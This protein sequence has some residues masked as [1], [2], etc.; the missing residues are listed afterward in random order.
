[1]FSFLKRRRWLFGLF[2]V[3]SLAVG[4]FW[5][6][7]A[8]RLGGYMHQKTF[9][10]SS[11]ADFCESSD[12]AGFPFRLR[13]SCA[14]FAAPLRIGGG[15]IIVKTEE[16]HG[17]ANIFAPNHII[18]TLSSP[19]NLQKA[20]GAPLARLRHDGLTLDVAWKTSGLDKASLDIVALD[21]RPDA[22]GAG[23]AFNLQKLTAQVAWLADPSGGSVH[24]DFVGDGLTAPVLQSLLNKN[25][26]GRLSLSGDVRPAPNMASDLRTAAED[27]RQKPGAISIDKFEWRAA[28]ASLTI[29][30]AL[31]VDEMHRPAGRLN[32]A[33][34]GAG[35]ILTQFGVPAGVARAQNLIGALLGK[36]AAATA[37]GADTLALPLILAK[38]QVF[39]GPIRLP[40]ALAPLY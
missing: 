21:W 25:D 15:D 7:A 40:V 4:E 37:E 39:L 29:D 10:G 23:I 9:G 27:W 22:P 14:G 26:L 8:N 3:V 6:Y 36:P 38:G 28:D 19:L 12:I 30:G 24:F 17:E 34:K 16:A 13:L 20:D 11:L 33:A 35:P 32:L 5:L 2:L 1:M 31:V 18:L